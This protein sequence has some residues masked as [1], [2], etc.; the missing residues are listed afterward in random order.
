MFQFND[1][2]KIILVSLLLEVI[3]AD[4]I[5]SDNELKYLEWINSNFDI[6]PSH[7]QKGQE[8]DPNIAVSILKELPDE[9]KS[10]FCKIIQTMGKI[11]HTPFEATQETVEHIIVKARLLESV[12]RFPHPF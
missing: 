11:D 3:N 2:E 10:A 8:F 6:M 4:G 7:Y 9:K 1:D 5:I 12:K